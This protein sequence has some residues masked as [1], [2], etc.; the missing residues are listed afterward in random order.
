MCLGLG[1]DAVDESV[2][3]HVRRYGMH[4]A[5]GDVLRGKSGAL[6]DLVHTHP[7]ETL[8]DAIEILREYGVSQMPV[9]KAEPPVVLGEVAG[10]VTDRDLLDALF[11]GTASPA[12][13]VS[14]HMGAKL[15]QIGAGESAAAAVAALEH[16]DALLVVEGGKPIGVVTR[17]DLLGHISTR[18]KGA[19]A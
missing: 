4:D 19:T 3:G 16:E 17:Q 18:A 15:P 2:C 13:P 7:S 11:E 10:A 12:D 1:Q 14:K 6:P 9:V 5:V 8:R